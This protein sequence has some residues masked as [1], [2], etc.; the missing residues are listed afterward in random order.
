MKKT[1]MVISSVHRWDDTRIFH[2]QCNSLSAKYNVELHAP[3][4][5]QNKTISNIKIIGLPKWLKEIY[6]IKLW[7]MILCR[8][9]KSDSIIVHFHDPE[10]IPLCYLI[11]LLT[12]KKVIYDVHE[13]YVYSIMAREWIPRYL[14]TIAVISFKFI[15]RLCVPKFDAV[16]YTTPIVGSRYKSMAKN[17]I[18]IENYSSINT[19]TSIKRGAPQNDIDMIYLGRIREIRGV[20]H[21]IKAFKTVVEKKPGA[22]FHVVGDIVPKSYEQQLHDLIDLLDLKNNVILTGF[23]PHAEAITYLKKAT[24]GIVT[25]LPNRHHQACLP[26][27][28]FEYMASGLPVIASDFELYKGVIDKA[29]CGITVDP[30]NVNQ[31]ADAILNIHNNKESLS[32]MSE[33]GL[34]AFH[35]FYNWENEA[36]KLDALYSKLINN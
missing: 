19:F 36:L 7:I 21:A 16:I 9:L 23:K 3:A 1:V 12:K 20:S 14:K 17:S 35:R 22:K 27:K 33:N 13:H 30:E 15:E 5:F 18:S 2:R 4:D 24:C 28:I 29:K 10:L 32:S 6:R 8:A 26:N 31:I 34:E 11:K 25:F